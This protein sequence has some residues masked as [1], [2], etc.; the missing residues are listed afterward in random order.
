MARVIETD[1]GLG[2]SPVKD[3]VCC[4]LTVAFSLMACEILGPAVSYRKQGFAYH[5]HEEKI[6]HFYNKKRIIN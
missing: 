3:Q 4:K 6:K 2:R 5:V 1:P